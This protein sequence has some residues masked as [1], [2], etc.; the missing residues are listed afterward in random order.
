[1]ATDVQLVQGEVTELPDKLE[2]DVEK[3]LKGFLYSL[4]DEHQ[5]GAKRGQS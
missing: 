4:L 2:M 5:R 1:M 3:L